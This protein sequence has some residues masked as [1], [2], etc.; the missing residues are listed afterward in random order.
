MQVMN[1]MVPKVLTGV[2]NGTVNLGASLRDR[3]TLPSQLRGLGPSGGYPSRLCS[4]RSLRAPLA[5]RLAALAA[6][7][8]PTRS[9]RGS[10]PSPARPPHAPRDG[11]VRRARPGPRLARPGRLRRPAG[12]ASARPRRTSC[13]AGAGFA[14]HR[15]PH[16]AAH[17][18]PHPCGQHRLPLSSV[19]RQLCPPALHSA[20]DADSCQRLHR[21]APHRN[22]RIL[23]DLALNEVGNAGPQPPLT[24]LLELPPT[25]VSPDFPTVLYFVR[26]A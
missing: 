14:G 4:L 24:E 18:C 3:A 17:C 25:R 15:A 23:E 2:R 9:R 6:V 1:V 16:C 19:R 10:T 21:R 11:A 12:F 5:H 26:E 8:G 13:V 22:R 7:A 20:Q